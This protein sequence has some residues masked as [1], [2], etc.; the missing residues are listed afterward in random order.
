MAC[1]FKKWISLLNRWVLHQRMIM[2]LCSAWVH[3]VAILVSGNGR[4]IS[5]LKDII[6]IIFTQ[7]IREHIFYVVVIDSC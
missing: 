1:S 7:V 4:F 2:I 5:L 3:S 6:V